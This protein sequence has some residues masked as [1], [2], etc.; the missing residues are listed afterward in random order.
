MLEIPF[1]LQ[2][3]RIIRFQALLIRDDALDACRA[4]CLRELKAQP[5]DASKRRFHVGGEQ[6]AFD[7]RQRTGNLR[8]FNEDED[9]HRQPAAQ[10]PERMLHASGIVWADVTQADQSRTMRRRKRRPPSRSCGLHQES[11]GQEL[12]RIP[13]RRVRPGGKLQAD[14]HAQ[15]RLGR[16]QYRWR[17][18]RSHL[19]QTEQQHRQNKTLQRS[20]CRSICRPSEPQINPEKS[21]AANWRRHKTRSKEK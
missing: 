13:L 15:N 10:A 3:S 1:Q 18:R 12:P 11:V 2:E 6:A 4:R 21:R 8:E 9:R 16:G 7:I 20:T 14:G 17:T 5:A 19:G